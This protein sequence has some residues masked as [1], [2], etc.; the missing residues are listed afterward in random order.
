MKDL[1]KI[2]GVSEDAEDAAIKRA[3]RKLAKELHPDATGGD[4]KKT[5]RFKE[6]N[7]AYA[8]LGDS[9]KRSEYD[10]LKHAPMRPDGMPEGLDPEIFAR[11]FGGGAGVGRGGGSSVEFDLNDLF[12]SLF[13]GGRGRS[14]FGNVGSRPRAPR[15]PDMAGTL[16][17]TFAEAALG[18]RRTVQTPAGTSIEVAVPAGVESGG[19]MRVTG[20]GGAAPGRGGAPGDLYLE[21]VVLPDQHLA[22]DGDDVV[23][24]LRVTVAETALGARVLVPTVE[25][26][27]T[28]TIP[29]GTSGGGKLRLRGR[30][31]RRPDGHR[32]DQ[33]CHVQ[34]AVPKLGPGDTELRRLFEE[35]GQLTDGKAVRSF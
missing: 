8:V 16:E 5:E 30:G 2:L 31:I 27:V 20:Q 10:R 29:A 24:D 18:T 3:Y 26:S 35:L 1:Y 19:R 22:R 25:G 13:G 32:G 14:P 17:V 12:G 33:I 9:A 4:K 28:L 6:V 23:L 34:I 11:T 21:I 7:G 15:G